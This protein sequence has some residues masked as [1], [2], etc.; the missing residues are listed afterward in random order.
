MQ[1]VEILELDYQQK[2]CAIFIDQF[3]IQER[4][5]NLTSFTNFESYVGYYFFRATS[6]H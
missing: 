4:L 5:F 2:K 3:D 1:R 6:C